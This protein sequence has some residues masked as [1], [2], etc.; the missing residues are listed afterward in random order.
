MRGTNVPPT[1][2]DKRVDLSIRRGPAHGR[3]LAMGPAR[4]QKAIHRRHRRNLTC[5]LRGQAS[6]PPRAMWSVAYC[7]L[8]PLRQA[9][10]RPAVHVLRRR[11]APPAWS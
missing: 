11:T 5:H 6:A 7:R 2:F 9:S 4:A 3:A 8:P 1:R 10:T